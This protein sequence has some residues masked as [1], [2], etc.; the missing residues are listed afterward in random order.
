M[1]S[2]SPPT[3]PLRSLIL[4][5]PL[6]LSSSSILRS[7]FVP[8]SSGFAARNGLTAAETGVLGEIIGG[9][10]LRATAAR[11][12]I[13][14]STAHTHAKRIFAKTATER[15][16]ELIRRFFEATFPGSRGGT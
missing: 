9:K 13:T 14:E 4:T 11:L 3:E 8:K 16:T 12:K 7:I 5:A 1:S 2:R 10:G 6:P 15:Q